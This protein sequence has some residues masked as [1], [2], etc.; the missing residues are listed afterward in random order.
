MTTLIV[1]IR[2]KT[3]P[4]VVFPH[5]FY[6]C[7]L[8]HSHHFLQCL[9]RIQA[10]Q[11]ARQNF[12]K[13]AIET[14]NKEFKSINSFYH[15]WPALYGKGDGINQQY[16]SSTK[17]AFYFRKPNESFPDSSLQYTVVDNVQT[18]T[19]WQSSG[20]LIIITKLQKNHRYTLLVRYKQT[21]KNVWQTHFYVAPEW[22]QTSAFYFVS[23]ALAGLLIGSTIIFIFQKQKL[24]K[25]KAQ[26]RNASN[27]AKSYSRATQSALYF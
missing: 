5:A 4:D 15:D 17:L 13:N 14:G 21:P 16:F 2:S 11:Q 9:C 1:E 19:A 24:R 22:Y 20:H 7:G 6:A 18:D 8:C 23:I 26:N 10:Q 25:G 3:K 12:I 27:R